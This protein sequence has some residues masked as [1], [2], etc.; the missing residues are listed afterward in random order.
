[1][2]RVRISSQII[3]VASLRA[4]SPIWTSKASLA[5]MHERAAK[6]FLCTLW[7]CRSLALSRKTHFARPNRRACSQANMYHI[8]GTNESTLGKDSL[9]HLMHQDS[10]DLRSLILIRIIPKEHTH[11]LYRE[12]YSC[13][14]LKWSGSESMIRD[15]LDHGRSNEPMNPLCTRIHRF[16][17]LPWSEWSRMT[18]RDSCC[19]MRWG[20]GVKVKC[21]IRG[22]D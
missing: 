13:V 2:I 20:A 21:Q 1:M 5:R 4:S 12:I 9:V 8:K 16:I 19:T 18:W 17:D 11:R 7:L 15:D 3:H 10:S 6:P 22:D 14:P